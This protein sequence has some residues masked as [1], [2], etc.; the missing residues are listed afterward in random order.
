MYIMHFFLC[1]LFLC[2][3][4]QL[5]LVKTYSSVSLDFYVY[6]VRVFVYYFFAYTFT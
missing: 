5:I 2:I 1:L 6:Y 3:Y 4:S